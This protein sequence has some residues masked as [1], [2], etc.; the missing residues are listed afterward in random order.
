MKNKEKITEI[1]NRKKGW[2]KEEKWRK[3]LRSQTGKTVLKKKN[4]K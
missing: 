4:E 1:P 2:K 3:I